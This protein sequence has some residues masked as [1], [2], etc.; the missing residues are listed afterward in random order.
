M[1]QADGLLPRCV[2][3]SR[4]VTPVTPTGSAAE[5]MVRFGLSDTEYATDLNLNRLAAQ[6]RDAIARQARACTRPE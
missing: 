6:S 2:T 1:G 4:P 3:V 5:G